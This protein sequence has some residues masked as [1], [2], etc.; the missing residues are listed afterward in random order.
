MK[1]KQYITSM[2]QK[3]DLN[4]RVYTDR[5]LEVMASGVGYKAV[6]DYLINNKYYA[7][8]EYVRLHHLLNS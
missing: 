1:L 3:T 5:S 2:H 6:W 4:T 8:A 7:D